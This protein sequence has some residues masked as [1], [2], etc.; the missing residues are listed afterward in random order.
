MPSV[1]IF[2]GSGKVAK[3]ITASLVKQDYK[4]YSVIRREDHVPELRELGATPIIQ[5]LEDSTV[6]ELT[7]TIQTS[8]PDLVIFAA[9]AG[10]R[11]F[12]DPNLSILVDRDTAIRVFDAMAEANGTKR[13]ITISTIDARN[14]DKPSPTW[15]NEEDRKSSDK[16]WGAVPTYVKAKFE[17]DKDLVEQNSRRRLDYTII[18]PT[19]YGDDEPTGKVKAGFA[20]FSPKVSRKDVADVF[21]ACIEN[22]ATIGCVFEVS[23]GEVPIHEAVQ[24]VAEDKVNTFGEMYR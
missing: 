21:V 17:A 1:L 14:R 18:R 13:L 2:G 16:L 12:E 3:F 10:L 23:G 11:G 4:V 22:P 19:W 7:A 15:Y 6:A 20:G 5:S 24:R 9:G 8:T